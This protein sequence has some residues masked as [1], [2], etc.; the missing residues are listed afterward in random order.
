MF[1]DLSI[2]YKYNYGISLKKPTNNNRK[3]S[4]SFDRC[5]RSLIS[6]ADIVTHAFSIM[7]YIICLVVSVEYHKLS[8]EFEK[9]FECR[10]LNNLPAIIL[11][12]Y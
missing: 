4:S 7:L 1:K 5:G 6:P 11:M 12:F 8:K 10:N 9:V 2:S 3:A